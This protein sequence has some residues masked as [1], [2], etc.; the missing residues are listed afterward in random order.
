MVEKDAEL[1]FPFCRIQNACLGW[2]KAKKH[3]RN[4]HG[5]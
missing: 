3:P 4:L 2:R 5:Y 1:F